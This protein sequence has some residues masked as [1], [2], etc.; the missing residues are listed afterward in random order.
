L[1]FK[2]Y[3]KGD[4]GNNDGREDLT[5]NLSLKIDYPFADSLTLSLFS[6]YT[7]RDTS[8]YD[9]GGDYENFDGGLGLSLNS[10]F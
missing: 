9:L 1:S 7:I 8:G 10:R 6:G 2:S 3:D 4:K 5:H